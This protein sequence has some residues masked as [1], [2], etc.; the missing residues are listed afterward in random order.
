MKALELEGRRFGRLLVLRRCGSRRYS[1]PTGKA[2]CSFSLWR[3][4]CDCGETVETTSRALMSGHS[5][6]C[7][8]GRRETKYAEGAAFARLFGSY[9]NNAKRRAIPFELTYREFAALVKSRCFYTGRPPSRRFSYR[10]GSFVY[11]GIDRQDPAL[12]Y[13]ATNCVPCCFEVNRAKSDMGCAEFFGLVAEVAR[14][15]GLGAC[16][17]NVKG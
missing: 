4:R 14:E 3:C 6:G 5:T 9:K 15:H 11:N 10:G 16:A 13:T 1:D 8:C 2:R 7:G 17:V 12:G